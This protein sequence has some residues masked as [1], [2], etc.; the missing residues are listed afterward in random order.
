MFMTRQ[1]D[2]NK[3]NRKNT[4]LTVISCNHILVNLL[5]QRKTTKPLLLCTSC[6]VIERI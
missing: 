3:R 2:T 6:N 1:I 5:G 4:V